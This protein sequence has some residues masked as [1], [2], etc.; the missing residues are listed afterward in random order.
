MSATIGR[1]SFTGWL[2][3]G[4]LCAWTSSAA[5]AQPNCEETP[6]A[7]GCPYNRCCDSPGNYYCSVEGLE[8]VP[9]DGGQCEEYGEL[10]DL[11][12]DPGELVNR[13]DD[14]AMADVLAQ[15]QDRM[16]TF[17]LETGDVVPFDSDR[18]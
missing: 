18:R 10:Y 5:F 13:I 1:N 7:D 4:V 12:N 16:L 2:I 6:C 17:F 11:R 14:P 3:T 15:L 9:V 8:E